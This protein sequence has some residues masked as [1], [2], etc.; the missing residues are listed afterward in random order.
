MNQRHLAWT[1]STIGLTCFAYHAYA[2]CCTNKY[3][4]SGGVSGFCSGPSSTI[5]DQSSPDSNPGQTSFTA[6]A[7]VCTSYQQ[8]NPANWYSGACSV[9]PTGAGW[10]QIS[11]NGGTCCWVRNATQASTGLGFFVSDCNGAACNSSSGGDEG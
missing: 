5:C 1:F 9:P 6:R 4:Y 3:T 11:S 2:G 8:G 7:A 10:L